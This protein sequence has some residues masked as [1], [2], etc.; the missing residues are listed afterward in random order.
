MAAW[1][2][3]TIEELEK[4]RA[5][6]D[7]LIEYDHGDRATPGTGTGDHCIGHADSSHLSAWDELPEGDPTSDWCVMPAEQ[8]MAWGLYQP[9]QRHLIDFANTNE[10]IDANKT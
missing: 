6:P 9:T 3:W 4:L 1:A 7:T 8:F 10:H 5:Q 2:P